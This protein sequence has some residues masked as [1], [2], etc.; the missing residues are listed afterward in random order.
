MRRPPPDT[1]RT[2]TRFPY[3]TLFRSDRLSDEGRPCAKGTGDPRSLGGNRALRSAARAA[4]RPRTLHPSRRPALR[5]WRHPYGP[6]HEQGAEGRDR[7]FSDDDGQGR[8]L[9]RKSVVEGKS[10]SVRV[11]LGG[12][13]IIKKKKTKN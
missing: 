6:R 12:R 10:V 7:A 4:K 13:R 3:T 9:D 1:T 5:Q 11:D 8:A 2:Y